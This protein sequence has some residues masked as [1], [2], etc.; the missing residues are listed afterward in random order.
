MAYVFLGIG[1][2]LLLL[3]SEAILRG[4]KGLF[5]A[6]GI[7]PFFVS[8]LI[9]SFAM[10]APELSVALQASARGLPDIALGDIVGSSLAN[11]L[12]VFGLGALIRPMPTPPRVVFRDGGAFLAA[13]LALV[14]IALGSF[15]GRPLGALL[16]AGWV[17]Y[18]VL[19]SITDLG[20][21]AEPYAAEPESGGALSFF[22]IAVGAVG[23]F[24]GARLAIDFAVLMAR[25]FHLPQ[26]A[27]ALTVVAFGTSLPELVSTLSSAARGHPNAISGRIVAS[28]V[29][30]VLLVLGIAAVLHPMSIAPGLAQVDMPIMAACAVGIPVLMLFGWRLTRGQGIVLLLG[31]VA[32]VVSIGLRSGVHVHF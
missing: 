7:P 3:G 24:F 5:Q 4:G 13:S 25:D 31:Y 8:L 22:L 11:L 15:I 28:N 23:L 2:A 19:V 14:F 17:G 27:V 1:F 12:L 9:G 18:L 6:F 16:L 32:Y 20:R 29:F 26:A 21:T 30:N 10:A